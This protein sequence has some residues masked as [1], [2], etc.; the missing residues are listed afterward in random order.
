MPPFEK[1]KG[2]ITVHM[3]KLWQTLYFE[4]LGKMNKNIIRNILSV[5]AKINF[6]VKCVSQSASP[7]F[8]LREIQ[9]QGSPPTH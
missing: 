3:K 4:D 7:E 5:F 9:A 6:T 8:S 1:D 2:K